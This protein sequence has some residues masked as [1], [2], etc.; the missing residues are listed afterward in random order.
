M[1]KNHIRKYRVWKGLTQDELSKKIGVSLSTLRAFER[2]ERLPKY[3]IR[4]RLT[5][6]FD[7][8]P[9]QLWD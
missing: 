8:S 1:V 7:V 5:E 6:F 4:Q 9:I 3:Q 2:G